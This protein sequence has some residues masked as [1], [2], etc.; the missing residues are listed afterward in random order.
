M[1]KN[2]TSKNNTEILIQK[3]SEKGRVV[4]DGR[5]L[6]LVEKLLD[7]GTK[8]FLG[9]AYAF[10]LT[11]PAEEGE[12]GH[13]RDLKEIK[14][15]LSL[16][17]DEEM[18]HNSLDDSV[19]WGSIQGELQETLNKLPTK[20]GRELLHEVKECCCLCD[21]ATEISQDVGKSRTLDVMQI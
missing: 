14:Q 13:E 21:E 7:N 1:A 11:K 12:S 16:S 18:L 17:L 8:L 9:R 5:V 10:K 4:V 3:H 19:A 20:V 15:D 2:A 6:G